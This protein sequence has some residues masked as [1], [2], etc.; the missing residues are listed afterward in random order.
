MKTIRATSLLLTLALGVAL[1]AAW[2]QTPEAAPA[3]APAG[4]SPP[5]SRNAWIH[6]V[7]TALEADGIGWAMWDYR[8]NFGVVTKQGGE[9]AVPDPATV[10]ALG[11]SR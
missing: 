7:R 4:K 5:A 1:P 6:D 11:L 10:E 8:A 3:R 2:A 9:A